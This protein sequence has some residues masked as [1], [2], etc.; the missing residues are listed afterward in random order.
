MSSP[1]DRWPLALLIPILFV[2]LALRLYGIDWDQGHFFHPDERFILQFKVPEIAPLWPVD[3]GLLL[4]AGRSPWNPHWFAYG[5]FPL[6]LLKGVQQLAGLFSPTA[7][8]DVLRFLGRGISAL[9]DT[10]SVLLVYL[11]GSRLYGRKTGLLAAAFLAVAVIHVQ[12]GHFAA[13]D[14]QL[15]FWVILA[16][17]GAARVAEQGKLRWATLAGLALGLGLATKVSVLPLAVP[18]L[19]AYALYAGSDSR[20]WARSLLGLAL[21]AVV[22]SCAFVVAQPYALLAFPEFLKDTREQTEMALRVRDFPYTRQY[23]GTPPYLYQVEQ[24]AKW[25]L[26][27][28][29]GLVSW[30][31]LAAS[32]WW[33]LHRGNRGDLLLL[34]WVIPYFALTGGFPV[35]FMRYL[36]PITPFLVLMGARLLV[37][38]QDRASLGQAARQFSSCTQEGAPAPHVR[39]KGKILLLWLPAGAV[40]LATAWYAIAFTDIYR[41]PHPAVEMSGWINHHVPPGALI[42]KEHWEEGVPGLQA[43][44]SGELQLYEP[45][46]P[47]KLEQLSRQLAQADYVLF[48]SNRLYGTIP[49]LPERYPMSTE[50]YRL[51]FSGGLGYELVHVTQSYPS[52]LGVSWRDDTFSGPG[53]AAP[54]IDAEGLRQRDPWLELSLG[55]ADESFTVY[56]HPMVMLFRRARALSVGEVAGRLR[57]AL[58]A[59]TGGR[60]PGGL[61]L[62]PE[63]LAEQRGGG[64]WAELFQ[65][66]S[67]GD[68]APVLAWLIAIQAAG[69]LAFPLA[70]RIFSRFPDRGYLLAKPLGL[71]LVAYLVWLAAS[72][73][74]A[75]FSFPTILGALAA[76]GALGGFLLWRD[77]PTIVATVRARWHYLLALEGIFLAAFFLFLVV[78]LLNPDLWHPA[79]GGE[80]PMDFAYLNAIVKSTYL[81][82]YDPWFSGGYI[83]YYYFGQFMIAL[84]IKLT[85][86]VPVVAYNLA[87]PALFALLVGNAFSVG[88]ALVAA[89][90]SAGTLPA[91]SSRL[92]D[93]RLAGPSKSTAADPTPPPVSRWLFL[94]GGATAL[95]VAVLGN[96]DGGMQLL[97]G[98]QKAGGMGVRSTI[99][100]VAGLVEV[101]A[102]VLRGPLNGGPVPPFD[103]WRS[104]AMGSIDPTFIDPALRAPSISITEFPF[105][106]FLFA[107]LH[108][109]LI[110]LPLTV[111]ALGFAVQA[112]LSLPRSL[113]GRLAF[114]AVFGLVLGAL[115]WT[116]SWDFPTYLAIAAAA[117]FIGEVKSGSSTSPRGWW[118]A[119]TLASVVGGVATVFFFSILFFRPFQE[120]YQLFFSGGV[121]PSPEMTPPGVYLRIHGLFLFLLVS[122]VLYELIARFGNLALFRVLGLLWRQRYRPVRAWRL[123][124]GLARRPD[125]AS[126]V[127]LLALGV[128]LLLLAMLAAAG[129]ATAGL[130]S[131]FLILVA[132]L[133]IAELRS[134]SERGPAY[135]LVLGLTGAAAGLG[136]LVDLVKFD[137]PGEVQRMNN[138]F[139]LYLQAWVLYAVSAAFALWWVCRGPHA[140]VPAPHGNGAVRARRGT[141]TLRWVWLPALAVLVGLTLVY[142]AMATPARV[143]DRFQPMP[144]SLDGMAYMASAVHREQEQPIQLKWDREAILWLQQNVEGSPVMLEASTPIYR[145]GSRVSIYTGLPTVLG[146][147]WHQSQQR[148]GHRPEVEQRKRDVAAIYTD[149]EVVRALELLKKY[150]VSYVYIGQ[151]ERVFYPEAGLRKFEAMAGSGQ[152]RQVYQNQE[153]R[154]YQV[155]V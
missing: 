113:L 51:L 69:L 30:L 116:N 60:A 111:L 106:T 98:L 28:P 138:V 48:F 53:L 74:I 44:R 79:R 71:L 13:F 81:P 104:R 36:L 125:T 16:L 26:G 122:F 153:V 34:S 110:A 130:L 25:G 155:V 31:G 87:V 96:L 94:G 99:P 121:A 5:S 6:Y 112:S 140:R 88:A 123:Y 143:T 95:G 76:V 49:R 117:I 2:S 59:A 128:Y 131:L 142:P 107:D 65:P 47:A 68:R 126:S 144:P 77:L 139:K 67:L 72:L 89:A 100:G 4:D 133:G 137:I 37:A 115:R 57:P 85:G 109:H 73:R 41:H 135:L 91:Q 22:A 45:D 132:V 82:P 24:L 151:L 92:T 29:L 20:R 10:G 147:D 18:V 32:A 64:T 90:G 149:P 19:V 9:A 141:S 127:A 61:I 75:P 23:E 42:L 46:T 148:W 146:W 93:L 70:H 80:K 50:Y 7:P 129:A 1:N 118:S 134:P 105:F 58:E 120:T 15:T 154:I 62:P 40:L 3:F 78:R 86:V 136:L 12:L 43:Y 11:L 114:L 55:Y 8:P 152:L 14:V 84:L 119:S 103:Y 33:A 108:A 52:F 97:E 27:W 54:R 56:D 66:G 38:W 150:D 21:V 101:A 17:Y 102:G 145:W 124:R 39:G 83:N 63:V 35:K